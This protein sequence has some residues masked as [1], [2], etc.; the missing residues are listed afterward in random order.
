VDQGR[1]Q[2]AEHAERTTRQHERG[3]RDR[4][5][6]QH[7]RLQGGRRH[8]QGARHERD[9]HHETEPRGVV[10]DRRDQRDGGKAE[11]DAA[12]GKEVLAI[13]QPGDFSRVVRRAEHHIGKQEQFERHQIGQR[14]RRQHQP[15]VSRIG[16]THARAPQDLRA[17]V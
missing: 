8:H 5:D 10:D 13:V 12:P 15:E 16:D 1:E 2:D 11:R 4:S 14:Q 6:E 17:T 3:Q 7:H 9:P